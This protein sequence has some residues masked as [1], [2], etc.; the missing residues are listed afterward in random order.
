M[1]FG[2][3]KG[4]KFN[5]TGF[6]VPVKAKAKAMVSKVPLNPVQRKEVKKIAEADEEIKEYNQGIPT[7]LYFGTTAQANATL[8][9]MINAA[10]AIGDNARVGD[11]ITLK[12]I[13]LRISF[14]NQF[15]AGSN[16][17]NSARLIIFQYKANNTVP[18]LSVMFTTGANSGQVNIFSHINTDQKEIYH[19][20]CDRLIQ[21]NGTFGAV[22]AQSAPNA[23]SKNLVMYVPLKYVKKK[24]QF[25]NA[26]VN[27]V[28]QIY[29]AILGEYGSN[30]LNPYVT[31][32]WQVKFTD[33]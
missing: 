16:P 24:I 25:I 21:T 9:P 28:N 23:L 18:D 32:D 26:T 5:K 29:F 31:C 2:D 12:S 14:Y 33:A 11:Q 15:G 22:G 30:T 4:Y 1:P 19:L 8:R 3:F 10:Q 20:L 6:K 27:A 17:E 13:K 7:I